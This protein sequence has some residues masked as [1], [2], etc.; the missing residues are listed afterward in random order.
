MFLLLWKWYSTYFDKKEV[1]L[2]LKRVRSCGLNENGE[3]VARCR[4]CPAKEIPVYFDCLSDAGAS[5]RCCFFCFQKLALPGEMEKALKRS[6][7]VRRL[8]DCDK[9]LRELQA[10]F[11]DPDRR[12]LGEITLRKE[13]QLPFSNEDNID[14][15][16]AKIATKAW[17][18]HDRARIAGLTY[19]EYRQRKTSG[20]ADVSS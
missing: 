17:T 7:Y 20:V 1:R 2:K 19:E 9:A 6:K 8:S 15:V 4:L 12:P 16:L 3:M 13:L 18:E 14:R 5:V 11:P 10:E